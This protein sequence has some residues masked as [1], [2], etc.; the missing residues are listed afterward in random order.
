[1]GVAASFVYNDWIALFPQFQSTVSEAQANLLLELATTFHR[2][3]GGGPVSDVNTQT[4][5]L[6]LMMAH[7]AQLTFGSSTQPVSPLVGRVAGANEGSVSVQTENQYAPGSPQWYQQTQYGSMYWQMTAPYRT[8]R[9][10]PGPRR[11]FNLLPF[12]GFVGRR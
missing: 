12:G 5:L 3:D 11:V 2:N 4:A 10:I 9:Y 8:M 6:N 1:M 7:V